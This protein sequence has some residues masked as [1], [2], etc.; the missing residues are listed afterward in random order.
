MVAAT[1]GLRLVSDLS[2]EEPVSMP[3]ADLRAKVLDLNLEIC[4][5]VLQTEFLIGVSSVSVSVTVTVTSR[6]ASLSLYT[7]SSRGSAALIRGLKAPGLYSERIS[8][9]TLSGRGSRSTRGSKDKAKLFEKRG[10][11]SSSNMLSNRDR[12]G[13]EEKSSLAICV[14]HSALPPESRS[15]AL[16]GRS[17][18]LGRR[19]DYVKEYRPKCKG[20]DCD[21]AMGIYRSIRRF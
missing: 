21:S 18:I 1:L 20:R 16:S 6:E 9:S 8:A 5:G 15:Q 10:L 14:S 11:I 7:G 19:T 3:L 17:E 13:Q 4:F 2:F 12:V